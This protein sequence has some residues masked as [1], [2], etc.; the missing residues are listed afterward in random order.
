[1]YAIC[2]HA[3]RVAHDSDARQPLCQ[4]SRLAYCE[5]RARLAHH[6]LDGLLALAS[7]R[8][9]LLAGLHGLRP[10]L[11]YGRLLP[12]LLQGRAGKPKGDGLG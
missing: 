11:V 4:G 12:G 9:L 5:S 6:S 2:P 7:V 3:H 10:Q 8:C 1:M